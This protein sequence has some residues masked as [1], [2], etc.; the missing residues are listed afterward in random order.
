MT[1]AETPLPFLALPPLHRRLPLNRAH[2]GFRERAVDSGGCWMG[3]DGHNFSPSDEGHRK[4]LP[5]QGAPL[6]D[7][8]TT[9]MYTPNCWPPVPPL[10][11][12]HPWHTWAVTEGPVAPANRLLCTEME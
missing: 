9:A 1:H 3:G 2:N 4:A 8:N 10:A 5:P 11:A 6:G 7:P 12:P